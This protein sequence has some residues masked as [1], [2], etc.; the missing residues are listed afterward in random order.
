MPGTIIT[1]FPQP[2]AMSGVTPM[3]ASVPPAMIASAPIARMTQSRLAVRRRAGA[4]AADGAGGGDVMPL[5]LRRHDA[6]RPARV[7]GCCGRAGIIRR[8]SPTECRG[9]EVLRWPESGAGRWRHI[10]YP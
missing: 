2:P 5:L 3:S 1:S 10:L 6:V 9:G 8:V 7:V 4:A